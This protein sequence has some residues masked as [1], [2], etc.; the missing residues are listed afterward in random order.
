[1]KLVDLDAAGT[2]QRYDNYLSVGF[3]DDVFEQLKPYR[4]NREAA[5]FVRLAVKVLLMVGDGDVD[6]FE[7]VADELTCTCLTKADL[8]L[9]MMGYRLL[10]ERLE[11]RLAMIERDVERNDK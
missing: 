8:F 5:G 11:G 2:R 6:R 3:S 10:S 1:M 7:Y 4:E 9:L